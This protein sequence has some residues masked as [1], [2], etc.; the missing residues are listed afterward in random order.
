MPINITESYFFL[1]IILLVIFWIF[2]FLTLVLSTDSVF[3]YLILIPF[4]IS[5]YLCYDII[6]KLNSAVSKITE[7]ITIENKF[8]VNILNN[9]VSVL[10][11]TI[12]IMYVIQIIYQTII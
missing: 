4:I 7:Y 12:L 8:I 11:I 5:S 6:Q 10:F 2:L 9:V 1:L 3:L